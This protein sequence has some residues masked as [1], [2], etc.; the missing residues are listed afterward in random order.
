MSA[1]LAVIGPANAAEVRAKA[2]V[3]QIMVT[4]GPTLCT[5]EQLAL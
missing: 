2:T 3:L 5:I 4:A 1:C